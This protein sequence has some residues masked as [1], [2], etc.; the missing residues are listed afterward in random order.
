MSSY[1]SIINR[2]ESART[3]KIA[4]AVIY[5]PSG[6]KETYLCEG[7]K[8]GSNTS[9]GFTLTGVKIKN[10]EYDNQANIPR[11]L[12]IDDIHFW[13]CVARFLRKDAPE[14]WND[15]KAIKEEKIKKWNKKSDDDEGDDLWS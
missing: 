3:N 2:S 8:S 4:E 11:Y 5:L 12:S 13:N 9:P 14:G 10:P 6:E 7:V 1:F 15:E